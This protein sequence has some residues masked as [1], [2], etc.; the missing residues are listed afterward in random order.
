[1]MLAH[2]LQELPRILLGL[3]AKRATFCPHQEVHPRLRRQ[4]MF[5]RR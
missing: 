3:Q 1:M 2:L 5:L 4:L